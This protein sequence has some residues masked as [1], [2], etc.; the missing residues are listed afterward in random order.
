MVKEFLTDEEEGEAVVENLEQRRM[1]W[2]AA[3][4][5]GLLTEG[6]VAEGE[7]L[8]VAEE[9]EQGDFHL[10]AWGPLTLQIIQKLLPWMAMAQN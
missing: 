10:K 6:N 3:Q 2:T 7:D 5:I 8:D 9:E 1:E 4:E